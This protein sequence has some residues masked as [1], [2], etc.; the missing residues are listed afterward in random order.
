MTKPIVLN[1]NYNQDA[2]AWRVFPE[3]RPS[4][5]YEAYPRSQGFTF[6]SAVRRATQM[7]YTLGSARRTQVYLR[8]LEG[9]FGQEETQ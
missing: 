2:Q 7:T 5:F 4:D 8:V 6:E 9:A 1:L 3:N